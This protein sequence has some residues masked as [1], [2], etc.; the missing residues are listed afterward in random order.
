MR[1]LLKFCAVLAFLAAPAHAQST[2]APEAA[3]ARVIIEAL[4]PSS[5]GDWAYRWGALSTRVSR[6]M[7]WHLYGPEPRDAQQEA[8]RN[9]W[10]EVDG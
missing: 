1:R 10:I 9:G 8:Q 7:H 6:H 2:P 5:H 3:V 4:A